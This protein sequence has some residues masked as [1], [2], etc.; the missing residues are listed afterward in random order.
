MLYYNKK[1][2][3]LIKTINNLHFYSISEWKK[4]GDKKYIYKNEKY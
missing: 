1:N 3:Q 4:Y 2:C